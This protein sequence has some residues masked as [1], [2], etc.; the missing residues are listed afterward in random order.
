MVVPTRGGVGLRETP[1]EAAVRELEEECCVRGT[2]V[3]ETARMIDPD[4]IETVTILVEIGSQ[5]P[6]IG[7]DPEF[8]QEHQVLSDMRWLPLEKIR[9]RDRATLW[10]SGLMSIPEFLDVVSHWGDSLIYPS[11]HSIV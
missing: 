9:E 3:R 2:V 8:E 1:A 10:A 6:K 4:G 11:N 5:E 7:I